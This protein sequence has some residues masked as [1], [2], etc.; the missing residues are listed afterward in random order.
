MTASYSRSKARRAQ[1]WFNRRPLHI[2][3]TATTGPGIDTPR[4]ELLAEGRREQVEETLKEIDVKAKKPKSLPLAMKI[5]QAGL[6]WSKNQ[7][8]MISAGLGLVGFLAVFGAVYT[9]PA[10][11]DEARECGE[12]IRSIFSPDGPGKHLM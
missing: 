11:H 6:S 4:R 5:A 8:L 7:F 10:L 2:H 3:H 9:D 1:R 12:R